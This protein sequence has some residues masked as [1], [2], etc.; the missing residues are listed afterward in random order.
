[1]KMM[2]SCIMGGLKPSYLQFNIMDYCS[3]Y[4]A[5]PKIEEL[6]LLCDQEVFICQTDHCVKW[7]TD[8]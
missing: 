1:M 3:L 7:C 6:K 4:L 8:V 5:P 2:Y